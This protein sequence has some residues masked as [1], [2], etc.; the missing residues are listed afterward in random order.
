MT[1]RCHQRRRSTL[2]LLLAITA[3]VSILLSF[4]F[5]SSSSTSYRN[6]GNVNRQLS[7]W[8][9]SPDSL[10]LFFDPKSISLKQ[11]QSQ[12][13][14]T[15]D[16]TPI[17]RRTNCQ[18]IYVLGVE[19]SI[20]HGFMPVIKS[21]A[22]H[23]ID[24]IT[25]TQFNVIKGHDDLRRT[26]FGNPDLKENSP[27]I[28]DPQIIQS[29]I[30]AMCPKPHEVWKKHIILEGNSFPS[31]S[32]DNTALQFRVRRQ[33]AWS[34]MTA[35][36][37]AQDTF[38]LNHPTNLY[39]LYK[40]FS[41]FVDVRFIV[42]HRP[43]VDTVASHI[44]F[45]LGPEN[46]A[47]V[48]QGFLLILSRFLTGHMYY[49]NGDGSTTEIP[50]ENNSVPLWSIVCADKLSSKQ[51]ATPDRLIE[52]R[53][54]ILSNL[55]SFLGWP[56]HSCPYCFDHWQESKKSHA[57]EERLGEDV[58]GTLLEHLDQ[59]EGIWPPRRVEDDLPEQQCRA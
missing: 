41:P 33:K 29:T 59:L 53:Q 51:Y 30:E 35:D 17:Q 22:E 26:I 9:S 4:T 10:A 40:A 44:G 25:G 14:A 45:D 15:D 48:I 36:Q 27:P 42:L 43:F 58:H 1:A 56:Q 31:G 49:N 8:L 20:H 18:I 5:N 34:T 12:S 50:G 54:H 23:Q 6:S 55:A 39:E 24:P 52:A 13:L 47:R 2:A 16:D 28:N 37:I 57:A 19:G 3:L 7:S 21:L 46:H 32:A 38:A 11:P